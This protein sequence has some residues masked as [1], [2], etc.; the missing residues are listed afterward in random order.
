[1]NKILNSRCSVLAQI[2]EEDGIATGDI[3]DLDPIAES[4]EDSDEEG[5]EEDETPGVSTTA[6]GGTVR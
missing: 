4:D 3:E 6:D 5:S 2:L 1:M